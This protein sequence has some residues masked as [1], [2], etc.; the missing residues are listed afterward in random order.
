MSLKKF[1]ELMAHLNAEENE[2]AMAFRAQLA[3]DA[4]DLEW[5]Q[6]LEDAGVNN[7][8]GCYEAK[9]MYKGE[10]DDE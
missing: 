7:W 2:M 8:G 1:D 10:E 6:C 3:S 4:E 9:Q 5:L